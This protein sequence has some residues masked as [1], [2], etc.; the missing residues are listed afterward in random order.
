GAGAV[1]E[2]AG[3]TKYD[4]NNAGLRALLDEWSRTDE[5]TAQKQAHLNGGA[6]GGKNGAYILD[7]TTGFD[8]H[9]SDSLHGLRGGAGLDW[10]FAHQFGKNPKDELHDLQPGDVV[11]QI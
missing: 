4:A 9:A 1:I 8:E 11:T 3:T 6:T 7:T 5:T 2:I 10:F